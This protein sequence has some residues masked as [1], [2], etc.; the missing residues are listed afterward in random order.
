MRLP[1]DMAF[2]DGVLHRLRERNELERRFSRDAIGSVL[3]EI[4]KVHK[5][6]DRLL[7]RLV[8]QALTIYE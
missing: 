5:P 7:G 1:L 4:A 3:R 8:D 2:R 6:R